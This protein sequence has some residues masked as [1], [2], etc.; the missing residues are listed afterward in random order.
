MNYAEEIER[1]GE[2]F[3]RRSAKA[4]EE[5]EDVK[6]QA[7]ESYRATVELA[8]A[9]ARRYRDDH[10]EEFESARVEEVGQER[11]E[12]ELRQQ[13]ERLEAEARPQRDADAP[14]ITSRP[15]IELA[16]PIVDDGAERE[17]L[18]PEA[19]EAIARSMAARKARDRAYVQPIDEPYDEESAYYRRDSWLD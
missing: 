7:D 16:V 1:A 18:S 6:R 8:L 15:A 12:I 10:P 4:L 14:S 13:R 2:E 9:E 3:R 19:R 5:L 11:R 17:P